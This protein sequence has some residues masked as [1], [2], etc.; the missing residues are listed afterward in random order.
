[1]AKGYNDAGFEV[2]G[3]DIVPQPNYPYEFHQADAMTYRLDGFDVIH[4]SP[5][6]QRFSVGTTYPGA[7]E[8]WPDLI[9]ETRARLRET[10]LP[11]VIENVPNAPLESP[12]RLCGVMFGLNVIRHRNFESNV[13]LVVPAHVPHARPIQRPA[14]DGT[15]RIVQRSQ[16]AQVAGHGGES[17]SYAI[18][19][20]QAAMG[21]DWMTRKEL[22]EAIPPVYAE[23]LGKQLM[24]VLR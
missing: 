22:V 7:R 1:M 9:A 24:E 5:P 17:N 8:K 21:I 13:L 12:V 4:A 19:D 10:G 20:W 3:V 18:A 2:V 6:C 15:T 23:Y 16:Y 11:Y 14:R